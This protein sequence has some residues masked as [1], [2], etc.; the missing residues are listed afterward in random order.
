MV[1]WGGW[2]LLWLALATPAVVRGNQSSPKDWTLLV[3]MDAENDLDCNAMR[4]LKDMHEAFAMYRRHTT[5]N[6]IVKLDR[7]QQDNPHLC[8]GAHS[9]GTAQLGAGKAVELL[10]SQHVEVL[11]V[12]TDLCSATPP[13]KA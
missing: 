10:M 3:Y 12:R 8:P 13:H 4:D 9:I 6:V 11:K 5:M 2:L 7:P 1:R